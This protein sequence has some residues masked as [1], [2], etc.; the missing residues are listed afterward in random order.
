MCTRGK[1]RRKGG[2]FIKDETTSQFGSY[3]FPPSSSPYPSCQLQNGAKYTPRPSTA[4]CKVPPATLTQEKGYPPTP[5]EVR[6]TPKG[7]RAI[8]RVRNSL[9]LRPLTNWCTGLLLPSLWQLTGEVEDENAEKLAEVRGGKPLNTEAVPS[10][11][12]LVGA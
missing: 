10:L 7:P 9:P 1:E 6:A 5:R 11:C 3:S 2:C 8:S 12:A 4:K